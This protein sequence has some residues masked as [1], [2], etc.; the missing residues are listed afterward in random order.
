MSFGDDKPKFSVDLTCA[1]CGTHISE[2]P[3][4]PTGDRKVYCAECNRSYWQDK[5]G[6]G[7]GG[8]NGGGGRGGFGGGGGRGR[9][10]S[11][12]FQVNLNCADC[13]KQIT[14]LPFEPKGDKPVYCTDCLRSRR[15][16]A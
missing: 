9:A 4:Q 12:K 1:R 5:R 3:F 11:Q 10:P 15:N 2:L 13:G 7:F 16:A 14:E 8:G 6:S